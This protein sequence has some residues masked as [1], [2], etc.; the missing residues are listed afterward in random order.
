MVGYQFEKNLT[1]DFTFRQNARIAHDDVRFQ[2]LPGKRQA[3]LKAGLD[4]AKEAETLREWHS[5]AR[6]HA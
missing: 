6:T 4:P 2:T 5:H 3:Q 1:D